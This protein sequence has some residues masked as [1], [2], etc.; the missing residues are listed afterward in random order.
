[1]ASRKNARQGNQS[2]FTKNKRGISGRSKKI[3][4]MKIINPDTEELIKEVAEDNDA[5]L[6][7]KLN[8]LRQAQPAWYKKPLTERID[9]I[10]QFSALLKQNV[11]SLAAILTSEVGKPLQQSRN[12]VNGAMSR[13]KWLSENAEKYLS[14][15]WMKTGDNPE[16]KIV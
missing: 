2:S 11:E 14:D 9:I 8:L 12:E 10:R 15:E 3:I 1:M 16:E 4:R 5:S 7:E 6:K 13:I